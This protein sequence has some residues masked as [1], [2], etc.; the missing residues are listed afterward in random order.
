MTKK[1]W[2]IGRLH[3]FIGTSSRLGIELTWDIAEP[4]L[5]IHV[6]NVWLVIEV[7]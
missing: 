2:E 7:W 6:L 1:H 4:A 3:F 5:T